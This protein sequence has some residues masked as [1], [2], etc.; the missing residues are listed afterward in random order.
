MKGSYVRSVGMTI[1][2]MILLIIATVGFMLTFSGCS[3]SYHRWNADRT[4]D[5]QE[6]YKVQDAGKRLQDLHWFEDMYQLIQQTQIRYNN[7][8]AESRNA[9]R[10]ILNGYIG[11]YNGRMR[12]YDR[13][14]WANNDLPESIPMVE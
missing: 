9:V 13:A 14:M 11:E 5:I 2:L 8:S 1:L 12:S 7:A 3:R 10:N 4:G 6:A